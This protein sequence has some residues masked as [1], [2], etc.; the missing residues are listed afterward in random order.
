MENT[1]AATQTFLVNVALAEF[2]KLHPISNELHDEVHRCAYLKVLKDGEVFVSKGEYCREF[3]FVCH[4]LLIYNSTHNGKM[5][6]TAFCKTGD[7]GTSISGLYGR[8]PSDDHIYSLGDTLL[9]V[10]GTDDMERW[11]GIYP[12]VNIIMR[13]MFEQNL[14]VAHGRANLIRMGTAK[15]KYAYYKNKKP[16]YVDT[17]PL[18]VIASFLGIKP[19]TLDKVIKEEGKNKVK[20]TKEKELYNSLLRYMAEKKPYLSERMTLKKL[21]KDMRQT[22]HRISELVNKNSRLNFND[23]VNGYRVAYIVDKLKHPASWKHLKLETLGITAGFRSRSSFYAVFKKHM[24]VSPSAYI[25]QE[26]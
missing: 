10:I 3:F 23:F 1:Y 13:Q 12:A 16:E 22:P 24:G 26:G 8:Q 20:E 2:S 18:E 11:Y 7:Y 4:G 17:V 6:T 21:A 19:S 14:K 15:E 25:S 9:M 5:F